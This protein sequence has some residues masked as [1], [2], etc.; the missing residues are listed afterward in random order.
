MESPLPGPLKK[1]EGLSIPHNE[2]AEAVIQSSP[3]RLRYGYLLEK[4]DRYLIGYDH[5][6]LLSTLR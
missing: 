3:L 1:E 6:V 5:R 4:E 2:K